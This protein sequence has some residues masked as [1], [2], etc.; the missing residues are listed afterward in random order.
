ME[1]WDI[2]FTNETWFFPEGTALINDTT[3]LDMEDSSINS[4]DSDEIQTPVVRHVMA[5]TKV[6]DLTD[7]ELVDSGGNFCMCNNLS[8]MVNIRPITPLFGINM[9]AI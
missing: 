7:G 5:T 1:L 6:V 2:P 9:A 4:M 8:M 3:L